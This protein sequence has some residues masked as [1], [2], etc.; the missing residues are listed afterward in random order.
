MN[1]TVALKLVKEMRECPVC[2]SNLRHQD[3]RMRVGP[4][5]FNE[6]ALKLNKGGWKLGYCAVRERKEGDFAH[7]EW[8]VVACWFNS[9]RRERV[10]FYS[11]KTNKR[12]AQALA[13]RAPM[14]KELYTLQE[15]Y[16]L[17]Q[18]SAP[19]S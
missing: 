15:Q 11:K 9:T 13:A 2:R 19:R 18:P 3:C 5:Y 7:F 17:V 1:A 12:E 8:R 14:P 4:D 16:T 6:R 10:W